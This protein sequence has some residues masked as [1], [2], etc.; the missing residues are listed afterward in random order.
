[1]LAD[2]GVDTYIDFERAGEYSAEELENTLLSLSPFDGRGQ[3]E[4]AVS[5][6]AALDKFIKSKKGKINEQ[7]N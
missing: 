4:S 1:M 6:F 3:K 5:H 7:K 2:L